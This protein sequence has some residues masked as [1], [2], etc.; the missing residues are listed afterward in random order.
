MFSLSNVEQVQPFRLAVKPHQ[1]RFA[2]E[3]SEHMGPKF[4]VSD[5]SVNF[6]TSATPQESYSTLGGSYPHPAKGGPVSRISKETF[7]A[8]SY[9]F[10]PE[11]IE[12]FYLYG[13][14]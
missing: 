10:T 4:G 13:K 2:A 7:L 14:S 8:G 5:L 11:D 3:T 9:S 6:E 12:V 1:T